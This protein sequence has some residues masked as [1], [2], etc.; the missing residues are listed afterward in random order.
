MSTNWETVRLLCATL[1][2]RY[3]DV[4]ED[5]VQR[6]LDLVV[7]SVHAPRSAYATGSRGYARVGTLIPDRL[8]VKARVFHPTTTQGAA[9]IDYLISKRADSSLYGAVLVRVV[10][11]AGNPVFHLSAAE[12]DVL[13]RI[14]AHWSSCYYLLVD[15]QYT[16][17][18]PFFVRAVELLPFLAEREDRSVDLAN[19]VVR[20]HSRGADL[21]V[22]LFRNCQI[23]QKASI[24]ALTDLAFDW[25]ADQRRRVVE[26][27]LAPEGLTEQYAQTRL[28]PE[29]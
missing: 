29:P 7:S 10:R 14:L 28:F 22:T 6:V 4:C 19:A 5:V 1:L 3:P 8:A 26:L 13:R 24:R 21:F 20:R 16:P 15:E 27:F 23:G 9:E 11:N 25:S 2:S 17:A 12:C 18:F